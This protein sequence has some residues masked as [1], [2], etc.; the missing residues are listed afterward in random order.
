[1]DP[2]GGPPTGVPEKPN[3]RKP[4]VNKWTGLNEVDPG[5][6]YVKKPKQNAPA[7]G[8]FSKLWSDINR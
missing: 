4:Y 8:L 7:T 1:M 5:P 2:G 6:G 3:A